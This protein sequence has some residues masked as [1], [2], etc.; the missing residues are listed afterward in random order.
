MNLKKSRD[1]KSRMCSLKNNSKLCCFTTQKFKTVEI[2]QFCLKN[3]QVR[4]KKTCNTLKYMEFWTKMILMEIQNS[5]LHP[6]TPLMVF[7]R[8]NK[9]QRTI[10]NAKRRKL[11][12]IMAYSLMQQ[13]NR[14]LQNH[15]AQILNLMLKGRLNQ[16]ES[17]QQNF[18]LL[19]LNSH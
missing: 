9:T 7:K 16:G 8:Q 2:L 4:S 3:F 6:S 5:F 10:N 19:I 14:I 17:T 13:T 1:C 12:M 18:R 15:L 11:M